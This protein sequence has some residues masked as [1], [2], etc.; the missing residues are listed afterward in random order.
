MGQTKLSIAKE[1]A[2]LEKNLTPRTASMDFEHSV[3][4]A[5]LSFFWIEAGTGPFPFLISVAHCTPPIV[6]LD[7]SSLRAIAQTPPTATR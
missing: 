7:H 4:Q 1:G 5:A 3:D 6:S 2:K